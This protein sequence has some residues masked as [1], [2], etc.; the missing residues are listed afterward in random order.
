MFR[1]LLCR[2]RGHKRATVAPDTNFSMSWASSWTWTIT[3]YCVR[4]GASHTQVISWG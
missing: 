1:R 2:L 3:S 4:C